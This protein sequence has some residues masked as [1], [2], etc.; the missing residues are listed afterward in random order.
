MAGVGRVLSNHYWLD[1]LAGFVVAVATGL[2][3]RR[4]R[5]LR[6]QRA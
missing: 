1:V 5:K 2:V 4:A 3:L 6:L